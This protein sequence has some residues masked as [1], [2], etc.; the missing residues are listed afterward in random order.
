MT[1]PDLAVVVFAPRVGF[2]RVEVGDPLIE[3]F[4]DDGV[5]L[6]VPPVRPEDP[7]APEPHGGDLVSRLSEPAPAQCRHGP[8][9]PCPAIN[10]F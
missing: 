8:S 9:Y 5:C 3:G 7:L 6:R 2:R 1:H 4:H 10:I